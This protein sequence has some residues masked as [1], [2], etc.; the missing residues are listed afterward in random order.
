M[1][2]SAVTGSLVQ[3]QIPGIVEGH[4]SMKELGDIPIGPSGSLIAQ[5]QSRQKGRSMKGE[6][7]E[8]AIFCTLRP[9]S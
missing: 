4:R 9:T 6:E 3:R 8:E 5:R 1:Q 7:Q 2:T